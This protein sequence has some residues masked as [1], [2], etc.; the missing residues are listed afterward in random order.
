D[1]LARLRADPVTYFGNDRGLEAAVYEGDVYLLLYVTEGRSLVHSANNPW[2]MRRALPSTDDLGLP[3]VNFTLDARGGEQMGR[4]TGGN[5]QR[6]MAIVLDGQV[7]TAPTVQSTIRE[8]GRITGRFSPEDITYLVRVLAAGTLS[9][10][11]SPE[12]IS[13][14]MLGPSLGA[15]N[16]EKGLRAVLFSVVAVS[17]L[18]L[19]YYLVAGVMAILSLSFIILSIFGTMVFID[20]T[21]TM[22][23]LAGIA[24]IIGMAVDANVLIFERMR[25]E[26]ML[27]REPLRNAARLGFARA[28][29]AIFDGNLTNLIVCI[30]LIWLAGTEVKGFGVTTMIGSISTVIGGVWVSRVLMSIY[31]E[32]MG[33]RRLPMVATVVPAVNRWIV[34]RIDWVKW[35]PLLLGGAFLVAASGIAIAALRGPDLLDTE[36]RGGVALTVTTKRVPT[37]THTVTAGETFASIAARTPGVPAAAIEAL[38][39]GVDPAAPPAGAVVRVPTGECSSDGRVLLT[40]E[41]VERRLQERGRAEPADSVVGQFRSAT[42]LTLGD[43]TPDLRASSFQVKV[44][45]P[46]GKVDESTITGE[47]VTAVAATL[48]NELDAQL[49]R[50]FQGAGGSHTDFTRPIDKRTVGE[51]L[52]RAELTDPVGRLKGGVAIVVDGIEPPISVDE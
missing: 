13:M 34:P 41:S 36:F 52:G 11:L 4:L 17:V 48:A 1:A 18:M 8:S 47:A 31:T 27:N 40:R 3:S 43:Q 39:P 16:L 15:D 25:E 24:L 42:V 50:T 2:A 37:A 28:F 30:V 26:L 6:P 22:P 14:S 21:F 7:Y 19:A 45:N 35:R 32:W 10:T 33:A 12:P 44:G 38:N 51:V 20:S 9:G 29:S 23:G 5:L 46:P 49:S